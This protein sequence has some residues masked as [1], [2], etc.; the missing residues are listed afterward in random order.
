M[1]SINTQTALFDYLLKIADDRL[2]LG[3][4]LSETCGHG[5]ILEEDIATTNIALDLIGQA[6]YLLE[7][8]AKVE[9]K[10]RTA[11]D[12][13]FLRDEKYFTNILLCEQD[14]TDFAYMIARQF[15]FDTFAYLQFSQLRES[16]DSTLSA[17]AKRS[18][19]E[20]TYH[21]RHSSQWMLRLGDGTAESNEK[22]QEA[23]DYLW[24]FTG[25]MFEQTEADQLLISEEIIFDTTKFKDEWFANINTVLTEATLKTVNK[26]EF[27][28]TGGRKGNHTEYLGHILAEMQNLQRSYPNAQW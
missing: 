16:K 26:D 3:H 8:A 2:I 11:D 9:E 12:L 13:A 7:Y 18:F 15:F 25:E 1:T 17:L 19:K 6:N 4:R 27:M 28:Q 20:I 22:L 23:I 24:M 21:L 14:N 5:P 10:D